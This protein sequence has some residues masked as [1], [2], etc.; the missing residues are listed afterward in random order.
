[1]L[2]YAAC[3]GNWSEQRKAYRWV[4]LNG[5]HRAEEDCRAALQCLRWMAEERDMVQ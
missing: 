5:G 2:A 3:C 1:M 4:A